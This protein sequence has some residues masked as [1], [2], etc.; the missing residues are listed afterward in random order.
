ME[1]K[2]LT[3]IHILKN[4]KYSI[5]RPSPNSNSNKTDM[6]NHD[7]MMLYSNGSMV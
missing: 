4:R 6:K 2:D 5:Q 3:P 1:A 7:P